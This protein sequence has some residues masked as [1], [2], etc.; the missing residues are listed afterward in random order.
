MGVPTST[1]WCC[2]GRPGRTGILIRYA[3]AGRHAAASA[4]WQRP[5]ADACNL[6]PCWLSPRKALRIASPVNLSTRCMPTA[7]CRKRCCSMPG[8]PAQARRHVAGGSALNR[9]Q[10]P[11]WAAWGVAAVFPGKRCGA[12]L[13]ASKPDASLRRVAELA[14]GTKDLARVI[15]RV[16]SGQGAAWIDRASECRFGDGAS[17]DWPNDHHILTTLP[18][19]ACLEPCLSSSAWP[20]WSCV[21]LLSPAP[22]AAARLPAV[23]GKPPCVPDLRHRPEQPDQNPAPA[24]TPTSDRGWNRINTR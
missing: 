3:R 18:S 14:P 15:Q 4:A 21:V 24:I 2:V 13:S 16:K 19:S 5:G 1:A 17:Q 23:N 9:W 22:R 7:G 11:P 12:V 10:L 8:C 6:Q 20:C